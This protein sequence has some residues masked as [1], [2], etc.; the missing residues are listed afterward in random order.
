MI[1]NFKDQICSIYNLHLLNLSSKSLFF[2]SSLLIVKILRS[3]CRSLQ[4]SSKRLYYAFIL[5]RQMLLSYGFLFVTSYSCDALTS[6]TSNAIQGNAPYLTFDE[7]R[8]RAINTDD[9]LWISLSNGDK[10][11]PSTNNSST[12]PI[13]LP[14]AGQSFSDIDMLM[15]RN[16]YSVGLNTLIAAPFNYWS[17]DD[18]DAD[19]SVT[20]DLN[21]YIVDEDYIF[22]SRDT[23]PSLCNGSYRVTLANTSGTLTTRYGIPNSSTFNANSVTY[24]I[25]PKELPTVCF[26]K[27]D[28]TYGNYSYAG[29]T[30]MWKTDKGFIPQSF[31]SSS[32]N[33]NFPTTGANNLFF[34]LIIAGNHQPLTWDTVSHGG[35]TATMTNSS[36]TGVRV[37]LTGPVATSSQWRAKNPGNIP[38]PSLPQTFELIGR[39]S[40]GNEVVKYGFELKQWFINRGT[41]ED[42]YANTLSWCKRIGYKVPKVKDL[43][44]AFCAEN[45]TLNNECRGSVGATPSSIDNYY[46]RIIGAGF[47]TEWGLMKNYSQANFS[48]KNYW[49]VDTNPTYNQPFVVGS[50]YGNTLFVDRSR[51]YNGLCVS[52]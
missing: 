9:L 38:S 22:L 2:N 37:T 49:T 47:F 17:D 25:N 27:P 36:N 16:S 12:T 5:S 39:D 31:I 42:N 40:Q 13:E 23:V 4:I 30:T 34:D 44:N 46:Q 24:H 15:P 35:I 10:Y 14:V 19:V 45:S 21:L 26:A 51:N 29:P 50:Y 48:F 28:T 43:T 41:F 33:L 11:T 6:I 1:C 32:Y 52:P 8:T 18:G 20:G 7:G 3:L